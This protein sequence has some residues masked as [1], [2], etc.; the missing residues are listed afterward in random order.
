MDPHAGPHR[1][2]MRILVWTIADKH[3]SYASKFLIQQS[4]HS[5]RPTGFNIGERAVTK[6]LGKA[7]GALRS[8]AKFNCI[9][10]T[11]VCCAL[12]KFA[13]AMETNGSEKSTPTPPLQRSKISVLS[14]P[15]PQHKSSSKSSGPRSNP[16]AT[17]FTIIRICSCDIWHAI[18]GPLHLPP[19]VVW[20]TSQRMPLIERETLF[21]HLLAPGST[22]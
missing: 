22:F 13:F 10:N 20:I 6:R 12:E 11:K 1:N 15:F 18:H 2:G 4:E 16:S 7:A 3:T 17:A 14:A 8:L 19:E 9:L 5:F 21:T